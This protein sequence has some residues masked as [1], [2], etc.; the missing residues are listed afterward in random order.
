MPGCANRHLPG[1]SR[2]ARVREV[3]LAVKPAAAR[4]G[5]TTA[6]APIVPSSR[7]LPS[8]P[9]RAASPSR[10]PTSYATSPARSPPRAV[11]GD[12]R[13]PRQR[14][15]PPDAPLRRLA[16][17]RNSRPLRGR[18]GVG[19]SCLARRSRSKKRRPTSPRSA[20]QSLAEPRLAAPRRA[21]QS[22]AAPRRSLLQAPRADTLP[23][24]CNSPPRRAASATTRSSPT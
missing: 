1:D 16:L 15:A 7:S 9:S 2:W 6:P 5:G 3:P 24:E 21:A 4:L 20:A 11:P 14:S 8:R 13:R 19:V 12:V 22:R 10:T 23:P 17:P 18:A